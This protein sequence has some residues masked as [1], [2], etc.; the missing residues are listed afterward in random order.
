MNNIEFGIIKS[1]M[2]DEYND[3]YKTN[4][5]DDGYSLIEYLHLNN[6]YKMVKKCPVFED[7]KKSYVAHLKKTNNNFNQINRKKLIRYT[8]IKELNKTILYDDLINII[9]SFI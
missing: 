2:I 1:Y 3:Y 7:Y 8:A 5:D 9:I 6:I 4:Y